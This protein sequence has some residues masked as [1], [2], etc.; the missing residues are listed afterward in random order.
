MAYLRIFAKLCILIA[1]VIP[2]WQCSTTKK[3]SENQALLVRQKLV[4]NGELTQR[5][6]SQNILITRPNKKLIGVP[7]G[8]HIYNLSSDFPET[9]FDIWL[10]KKPKREKRLNNLISSKQVQTIRRYKSFFNRW[11][12]NTGEPPQVIDSFLIKKSMDNLKQYFDSQGYFNSEVSYNIKKNPKQKTELNY[13]VKTNIQYYLDSIKFSSVSPKIDSLLEE[14]R[15]NIFLRRGYPVNLMEFQNERTRIIG[16]LRNNGIY[17]YQPNSLKFRLGIDSLAIDTSVPVTVDIGGFQ[18]NVGVGLTDVIP[19]KPYTVSEI[20]IYV[21]SIDEEEETIQ[22][23]DSIQFNRYNIYSIG[24]LKYKPKVLTEGIEIQFDSIYKDTERTQT[25]RYFTSLNNFRYPRIDYR[26][27]SPNST[28]L[29]AIIRLVPNKRFNLGFELDF[30]TSEIQDF[31]IGT[32]FTFEARNPFKGAEILQLNFNNVVGA[33]NDLPNTTNR[34]FNLFDTGANLTMTIPKVLLP[35][36]INRMFSADM[37]PRTRILFGT[38]V[39]SN[40]GLDKQFYDFTHQFEWNPSSK[41]AMN[42]KL[43]DLEY[44][45]NRNIQNFFNVYRTTYGRLNDIAKKYEQALPYQD[46]NRNLSVP[47]GAIDFFNATLSDR[48]SIVVSQNDYRSLINLRE[49]YDRLVDNNLILGSSLDIAYNSQE[50]INDENYH[51]IKGKI[52]L[53]G[54]FLNDVVLKSFGNAKNANNRYEFAGVEP[55]QFV[56]FEFEYVKQWNLGSRNI[57][58]FRQFGGVAIPFGNSTNIPF[59]QSY[60]AG[61]S[62]DN[63]AWRVYSLGPGSSSDRQE[64]NEA[65]FKLLSSLEYR[66]PLVGS[67][68]GA[69][70]MDAGNIWNVFDDIADPEFRFSGIKDLSELA[71]ALGIGLRY[72]FKFFVLRFDTAFKA[73]NPAL[74]MAQRWWSGLALNQ[75]VFNIGI[76]YPF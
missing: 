33:S 68:N 12:K 58:A 38:N 25:Y 29:E 18:Q 4:I 44:V 74:P 53:A 35:F 73:H 24:H 11:L 39:Q 8:L 70:F 61:G 30:S 1:I 36:G 62:N 72:D 50:G 69:F 47:E 63:R 7:L 31:G 49:R 19:Y 56:K 41:L 66:F 42:F 76:N 40:I 46:A 22:Y 45:F 16:F 26:P 27:I 52:H 55:S 57:L 43:F 34:F 2:A 21:D 6:P 32:T 51:R 15:E 65:N 71:L 5:H 67:L 64:L 75:A 48:P 13:F 59:S 14:N 20:S 60:F 9:N 54:T 37:L 23:T 3:L 10:K 17:N 28:N